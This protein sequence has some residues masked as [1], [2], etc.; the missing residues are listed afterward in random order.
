MKSFIYKISIYIILILFSG[1]IL[2]F[3]IESKIKS[4]KRYYFQAD[5]HDLG[6][7]NSEILLIGNSRIWVHT[8]PFVIQNK[9]NVK[10]EI[11][12]QDG[13]TVQ[14][15]WLK[16]KEYIKNNT[17]P[18]EI[19]L[20]YD[21]YF[22]N[23][24][25]NLNGLDNFRTGF[26]NDRIDLTSLK[27]FKG[28]KT[29]YRF[30]PLSAITPSLLT[31]ILFDRTISSKDSYVNTHGFHGRVDNWSGNWK[32]P[33]NTY[34]KEISQ[35]VDSFVVH[36]KEKNINLYFIYTPQSSPSYKKVY[37]IKNL[38][39]IKEELSRKYQY[40]ITFLNYNNDSLYNDSSLFYNHMHMNTKGVKLFM[41]HFI[42]DQ[43]SFRRFRNNTK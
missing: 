30:I 34:F 36:A 40:P 16:F 22:T 14:I 35:Y 7:H 1:L 12:A 37:N 31:K 19:Y 38:Y 20:L 5:W 2:E 9:F 15:L 27:D 23:K 10:A 8:D 4:G 21:P 42:K 17:P 28:Y 25:G 43:K 29:Y 13:Q 39:N 6:D 3:V 32:K 18:K 26:F 33:E 11:L 24:A 41:N